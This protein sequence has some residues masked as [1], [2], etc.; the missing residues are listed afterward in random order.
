[1]SKVKGAAFSV[2]LDGFGAGPRQDLQN[3]LG[4]RWEELHSWF[5][6]T[7]VFKKMN[8]QGEGAYGIDNDF[9]AQSMDNVGA[10]ILGRNMFGP[11]RGPWK[12]ESWKGWWGDNPPYHTPIFVLTHHARAPYDGRRH[13]LLLCH[14]WHRV[15]LKEG[16]STSLQR[17]ISPSV[18]P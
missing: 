2:S 4:A 11:V 13:D 7:D 17:V 8:D 9:A 14:R 1:M 10:W 12:D 16:E 15:G 3:P 6:D 5:V 18:M